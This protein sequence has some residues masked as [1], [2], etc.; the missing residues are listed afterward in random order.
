VIQGFE[1]EEYNQCL[2]LFEEEGIEWDYYAIGSVCAR[3]GNPYKIRHLIT[4]V[5][6]RIGS[7]KLHSFGLSLVYLRDPQI[8]SSIHSSDSA[9]WHYRAISRDQKPKMIDDYIKKL[10]HI[11]LSFEGQT[12]LEEYV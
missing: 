6:E 2:D 7:I 4:K 12:R 10:E 5:K 11:G 3:K 9:A 1:L 8:F